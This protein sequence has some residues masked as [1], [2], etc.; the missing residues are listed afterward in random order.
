MSEIEC[1]YCGHEQEVCHDDGEN[2]EEGK[3]NEMECY[4]CE[5]YFVFYTT[6]SVDY[7]SKKAE[8]LNGEGHTYKPTHTHPRER[9]RMRCD[10]CDKERQPTEKEWE[11]ILN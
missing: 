11:E 8:C 5:K 1:P 3:A 4:E 7:E 10:Q 9:S 2:Y 6:F